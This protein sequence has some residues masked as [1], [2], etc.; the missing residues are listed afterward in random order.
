M[1][2]YCC[3]LMC[4]VCCIMVGCSKKINPIAEDPGIKP[5]SWREDEK[6][7]F[8]GDWGAHVI[9]E[10][11]NNAVKRPILKKEDAIELA[12]L[13]VRDYYNVS[14]VFFDSE[15][16]MWMVLFYDEGSNR[17]YMGGRGQ[18]VHLDKNGLT[19]LV[20]LSADIERYPRFRDSVFV[21]PEIKPFSWKE[22]EEKYFWGNSNARVIAE[23]FNNI[24]EY[25]IL[26]K[27]DAIEL[28][29]LEEGFSYNFIEVFF[30]S[31]C[32]MWMVLFYDYEVLGG[33]QSVYIDKNGLTQ[34]IVFDE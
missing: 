17:N 14:E 31:E 13:E 33:G 20:V 4:I 19:R 27:E 1:K 21:Y 26:K 22:D 34:L 3:I 15:C 30:D 16:D 9:V 23:G 12:K 6:T 24:V 32:D 29:K 25:P 8:S 7:Y 5:F 10:G 11:F 2:K 18:S 28:A